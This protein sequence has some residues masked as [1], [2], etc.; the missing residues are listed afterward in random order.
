LKKVLYLSISST[1]IAN[2]QNTGIRGCLQY[3]RAWYA[4]SEKIAYAGEEKKVHSTFCK[5][6]V[7]LG[8]TL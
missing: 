7:G 3:L 2:L 6:V 1:Y 5:L 8:L 4:A